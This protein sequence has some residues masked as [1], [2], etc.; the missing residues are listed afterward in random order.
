[1]VGQAIA[2][3]VVSTTVNATTQLVLLPELSLTV[4]VIGCAP[5]PE[6]LLPGS[7]VCVMASDACAVQLSEDCARTSA[8]TSGTGA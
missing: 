4:T 8:R 2:G 1:L 5:K 3:P 7:G 6:T